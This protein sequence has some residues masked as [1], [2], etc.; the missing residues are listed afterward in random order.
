[1]RKPLI[2]AVVVAGVAAVVARKR[3][4]ARADAAL[5]HEAT[6]VGPLPTNAAG[7]GETGATDAA[8]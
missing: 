5:W 3:S 7:A 6:N 2:L 8:H 4:G 1:V